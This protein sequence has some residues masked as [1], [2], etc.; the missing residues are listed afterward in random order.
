MFM[1]RTSLVLSLIVIC[2]SL[3]TAQP[4]PAAPSQPTQ[5]G[6]WGMNTYFTGL[7]RI[8]RDGDD[9][10]AALIGLGR[11]AGVSWAR[12]ELSWGNL[13]RRGKGQWDWGYFDRRLLQ[14]A[15]S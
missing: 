6:F 12:E 8:S 1:R 4:L 10:V 13:E 5:L 15:Q 2:A 9:G 14:I 11:S 3:V 7:E